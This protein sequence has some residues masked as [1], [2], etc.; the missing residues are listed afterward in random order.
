MTAT[1]PCADCQIDTLPTGWGR[2]EYFIAR[3]LQGAEQAE[4]TATRNSTRRSA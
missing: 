1:A 3:A 4:A 2:A